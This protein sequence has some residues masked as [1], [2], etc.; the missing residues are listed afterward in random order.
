MFESTHFQIG[1]LIF[2]QIDQADFTAPFEVFSRIPNSTYHVIAK[3]KN[4]LRDT[5]GLILTPEKTFSEV[6]HLDLLHIPGGEGQEAIMDDEETLAFIRQHAANARYIFSVCTGALILG[7]AG[8][9][10]GRKATTHWAALHLLK[11]FGAVP[12]A[13]R[14]VIDGNV[15]STAGVTAGIDGA[16]RVAALLRGEQKAQEIQLSI[17]YAPDPPFHSGSPDSAPLQVLESVRSAFQQLADA[18]LLA[19]QRVRARLE[20]EEL[21]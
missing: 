3:E 1:S 12:V 19:A 4:P 6:E 17:Q 18:R 21:K 5:R 9:L 14:V 8:L 7:A 13:D 15:V 16:L 10:K 11:Y 2:P 20:I